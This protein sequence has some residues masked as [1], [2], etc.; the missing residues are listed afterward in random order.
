MLSSVKFVKKIMCKYS[1]FGGVELLWELKSFG[2]CLGKLRLKDAKK[3]TFFCKVLSKRL[4]G[5]ML[6]SAHKLFNDDGSYTSSVT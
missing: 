1:N 3:L 5:R 2:S 6:F 4:F